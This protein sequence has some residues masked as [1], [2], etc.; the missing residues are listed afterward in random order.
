MHV[1]RNSLMIQKTI[2]EGILLYK[3]FHENITG[4]RSVKPAEESREVPETI[5]GIIH[6]R[7]ARVEN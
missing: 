2:P 4:N 5:I 7:K 3:K 1:G 6:S